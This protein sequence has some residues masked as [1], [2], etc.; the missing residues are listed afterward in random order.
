M[1]NYHTYIASM[2][3]YYNGILQESYLIRTGKPGQSL[4]LPTILVSMH[5]KWHSRGLLSAGTRM[6][7]NMV[8]VNANQNKLGHYHEV[9]PT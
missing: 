4:A 6:A 8:F 2:F 5:E 7:F 9:Y 1:N 3:S